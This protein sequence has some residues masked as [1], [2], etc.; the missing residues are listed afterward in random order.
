MQTNNFNSFSL[1]IIKKLKPALGFL[2]S[3]VFLNI[4]M[5]INYPAVEFDTQILLKISPEILIILSFI[6]TAALLGFRFSRFFYVPLTAFVLFLR[7]FRI[8]DTLIPMYFFRPFN[9]FLDSQF[10]PDLIH[11]LYTTFT[12][13]EFLLFAV[14]TIALLV[15]ITTGVW[16]SFKTIHDYLLDRYPHRVV[17]GLAIAALMSIYVL[18]SGH[19]NH[20]RNL[21]AQGFFHRVVEEGDFI[22]HVQGY[23]E[24][25]LKAIDTSMKKI[26]QQPSS[27]DKLQR[28]NVFL[29]FVES[30]GHTLY[31]ENRHFAKILPALNRLEKDLVEGGYSACSTFLNSPT[32][33]G[34]SW[35]AH[36]TLGSGVN[37]NSQMRY[38]LLI[39][40]TAKTI[41]RLFNGIGYRTISVMPGTQWPWPE[42]EFFGYQK[43]YY[44]WDFDYKGPVYG[45]STMPDQYVLDFIFNREIQGQ[46]NPLFIE[47]ILISSHAPFHRQPPY[48]EDWSQIGNGKIYHDLEIITF[49]II[50]PDLSNASEG[51]VTSIAYELKV[52]VEFINKFIDDDSLIV[53]LGDHQPNVQITGKKASWSVPIHVISRNRNHLQPFLKRGYATGLI[54]TQPMPHRGMDTF[55]LD[56]LKDFSTPELKSE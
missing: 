27:M 14:L 43:K 56:F 6:C 48:V 31:A 4:L 54:P 25:Y 5:N 36:A 33:G 23:R 41:A 16:I 24:Q 17:L 21:F 34:S 12:F 18:Q 1:R 9:L 39:T 19:D 47:F 42:G 49:P 32:F 52:I 29:F 26:E 35:L 53:V 45:W 55:L 3:V 15:G 30:Y 50:W 2:L 22:L 10:L 11:L 40:S 37:L 28:S 7:L 13:K 8:G 51:Y 38:N 20:R 46:T 44:A